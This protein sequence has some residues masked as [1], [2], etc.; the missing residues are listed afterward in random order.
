MT[1]ARGLLSL[2]LAGALAV[3]VPACGNNNNTPT[4][5]TTG[6]TTSFS[7]IFSAE[8]DPRGVLFYS[9]A[10]TQTEKLSVTLASLGVDGTIT[11]LTSALNLGLGFP[12]GTGCSLRSQQTVTPGLSAQISQS[13]EVGTYCVNISD[14]GNLA[15]TSIFVIR[16][17]HDISTTTP[18]SSTKNDVFQSS[19]SVH[20]TSSKSFTVGLAGTLSV[21]LDGVTPAS[22]I[23]L[24][25]GL[26][27]TDGGGCALSR[28]IV[29]TAGVTATM[30]MPVDP[31]SYCIKVF[32][33]GT[34]TDPVAFSI[35]FSHPS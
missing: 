25:V 16:I 8:L 6:S 30:S 12:S 21:S 11:P 27:R 32:D 14:P 1:R 35:G 2:V 13:I 24:G 10:T 19:L 22:S 33:V 9:F 28:S 7:E 31:G 23:G 29:S 5:P 26:F 4:S 17:F 20:G 3:F 34:L 18:S 15:A